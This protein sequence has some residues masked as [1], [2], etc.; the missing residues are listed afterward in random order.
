MEQRA[1]FLFHRDLRIHDNMGVLRAATL[2][3]PIIPIF[4]ADPRQ[5]RNNPYKGDHSMRFLL[6]SLHELEIQIKHNS[7]NAHLQL[8]FGDTISVIENL[9]KSHDSFQINAIFS[10][11]D[12][13]PFAI[14]RDQKLRELCKT[15][16]IQ[17]VQSADALLHEPEEIHKNDG[18]P[19]TVFTPYYKRAN[20]DPI[21]SVQAVPENIFTPEKVQNAIGITELARE[22]G[23][24]PSFI[25]AET[26]Y[27]GGRD[28]GL[29]IL[30]DLSPLRHYRTD[31]DIPAKNS[32]SHLSP[33]LKFGTISPREAYHAIENQLGFDHPLLRQLFW[34]DFFTQIAYFYP[35]VFGHAFHRKYDAVGWD[36]GPKAAEK[37]EKWCRGITGFPIVD[38]GMRELVQ[39]GYMH[40]RVRMIVSS[41]L[42]K[43]L[44]LDW[45]WGEKFFAQHLVDYDPAVNNGNWQWSAS[46]GCD[47][48][49]Y[50]RIF[51]P[52]TQQEK[53]DP[54]VEYIKRWIPELREIAP[55]SIHTWWK[56]AVQAKFRPSV[57]KY[58]APMCDH[59]SEARLA[60]AMYSSVRF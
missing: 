57:G 21:P 53:F 7:S 51:N 60:K 48:Q 36:T 39:S 10:N 56:P 26:S 1:F 45:R 30:E 47:A 9:L 28:A 33:H 2:K 8:L 20:L 58:P 52:W 24:E 19:Y 37:F 27:P 11:R 17:W 18:K 31:R 32:T 50:F 14:A 42:V 13:T 35:H 29:K 25:D 43:D 55:A 34:R 3:I 54:D 40:N 22:T 49:P 41:F 38:A 12:Y 44:H 6:Q 4:I 23:L 59:A 15:Y 16:Q 46:T 5:I